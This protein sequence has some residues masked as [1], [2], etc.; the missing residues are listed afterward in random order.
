MKMLLYPLALCAV[1]LSVMTAVKADN[2]IEKPWTVRVGA[3]WPTQDQAK[4]DSNSTNISAGLDYALSETTTQNPSATS[5]YL[6]YSGGAKNGGHVY[7]YGLGISERD[8]MSPTTAGDTAPTFYYGAGVGGYDV[9]VQ[10]TGTLTSSGSKTSLGAKVMLG[11]EFQKSYIAELAYNWLPKTE[12]ADPSG[13]S[14]QVG[15]HF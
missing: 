9:T 10:N 13:L 4:T 8:Y 11:V 6:D 12:N 15:I 1:A 14:L 5:V 3:A 2:T 7:V